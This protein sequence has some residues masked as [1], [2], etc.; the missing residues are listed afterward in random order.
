MAS[1]SMGRCSA[2]DT[3]EHQP[4]GSRGP[5][6]HN[7]SMSHPCEPIGII[8]SCFPEKFGVPQQ[9]RL[10][11]AATAELELLGPYARAEAVR[12]LAAFSHLW[13]LFLFHHNLGEGWRP[14]VRPPRLGGRKRV[15]VF[16]SRSP[17]RPN[18]I[19]LS[20]VELLAVQAGPSRVLLRLRGV[21]L[22]DGTPVLDIKPYLPHTDAIPDARGGY[23]RVAT[24]ARLAVRFGES[25]TLQIQQADPDG[26][27]Q[28][29]ALIEQVIQQDPRPGYLDRY[30]NR[31]R[32]GL[33]LYDFEVSWRLEGPTAW[34]VAVT[35][36]DPEPTPAIPLVQRER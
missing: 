30:P 21:D 35:Q 12:G 19:G 22:V 16:A 8:R 15:G 7:L 27:H 3:D 34:V 1:S 17:F 4:H 6:G 29:A 9:P 11:P 23:A 24:P 36:H 28:L 5:V 10:V 32:F 14:T 26:S 31:T 2:G 25:A 33:R 18:P 13:V 20:A